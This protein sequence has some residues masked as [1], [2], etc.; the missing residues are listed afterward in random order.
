MLEADWVS[1][2]VKLS[3]Y[4]NSKQFNHLVKSKSFSSMSVS[5]L[6]IT[7]DAPLVST[8]IA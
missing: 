3:S 6:V 5:I 4:P 2:K 8:V 1:G 7:P